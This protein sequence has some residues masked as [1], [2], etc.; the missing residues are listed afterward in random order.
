MIQ[1][2][3]ER[4]NGG[5]D[6]PND[7]MAPIASHRSGG[8]S[9]M[10]R[11]FGS[12]FGANSNHTGSGGGGIHSPSNA[13]EHGYVEFGMQDPDRSGRTLGTFAGVFSPVALS[14]FSALV[15]IRVD[16]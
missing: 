2:P 6:V 10:F 1:Q 4:R 8:A 14:M 13:G 9:S 15:F 16:Y 11:S 12:L 7:E 3:V 5:G